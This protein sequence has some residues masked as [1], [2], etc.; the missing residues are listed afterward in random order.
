MIKT[1][2]DSMP[3]ELDELSRKSCSWRSRKQLLK[4]ETDRLY[5]ER[6]EDLQK[7]AGRA[8]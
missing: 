3:A 2:L 4:K 8:S 7:G 5:Q 6:L 1:E